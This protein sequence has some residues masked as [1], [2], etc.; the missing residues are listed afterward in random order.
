MSISLSYIY[1]LCMSISLSLSLS[2]FLCLSVSVSPCLFLSVSLSLYLSPCLS[3][4][5]SL[6]VPSSVPCEGPE[7]DQ[8]LWWCL[9]LP[10]GCLRCWIPH[11]VTGSMFSG[12][13]RV[14]IP[15]GSR[16]D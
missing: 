6:R 2:L 11:V 16:G 4:P 7:L 8:S 1:I 12:A 10:Q 3:L 13:K 15:P 5:V 14:T 9:D